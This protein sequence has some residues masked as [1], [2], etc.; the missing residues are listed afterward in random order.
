MTSEAAGD[1]KNHQVVDNSNLSASGKYLP[2]KNAKRSP[3]ADIEER[4]GE[5]TK[6]SSIERLGGGRYR[7]GKVVLDKVKR[8]VTLPA[9]VNMTKG[10]VEYILV[11]E[12]GKSHEAVFTTDA[13]PSDIHTACLLLGMKELPLASWPS[14]YNGIARENRVLVDVSWKGNGPAK[15]VAASQSVVRASSGQE[16]VADQACLPSGPWLYAGSCIEG[17]LFTADREGSLISVISDKAAL[18]NGIRPN[19]DDDTLYEAN[20]KLLPNVNFKVEFTLTL[21]IQ[22]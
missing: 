16:A 17:G 9:R 18:I 2:A 19:Y 4:E 12:D 20:S 1:A 7:I 10:V 5:A 14:D 3:S 21:P 8:T 22:R 6:A 15:K 13:R 11:S